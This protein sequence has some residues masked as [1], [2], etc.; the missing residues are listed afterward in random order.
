[1]N[2]VVLPDA[3]RIFASMGVHREG[4]I[5]HMKLASNAQLTGP[6]ISDSIVP[7]ITSHALDFG[8]AETVRRSRIAGGDLK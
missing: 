1:M 2:D 7:A 6:P 4:T 3:L 5:G 8:M